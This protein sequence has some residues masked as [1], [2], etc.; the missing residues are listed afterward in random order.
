MQGRSGPQHHKRTPPTSSV[1]EE[2]L[3]V[4]PGSLCM[5]KSTLRQKL[6]D[7]E[8]SIVTA[9]HE[10]SRLEAS[11][12]NLDEHD[13]KRAEAER[14]LASRRSVKDSLEEMRASVTRELER[15]GDHAAS[16]GSTPDN[17]RT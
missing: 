3:A 16:A 1:A 5:Q 8:G 6:R 2:R 10:I 13:K 11:I 7:L 17:K 9:E 12:A 15:S 14:Q 4:F